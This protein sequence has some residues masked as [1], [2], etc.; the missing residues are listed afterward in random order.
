MAVPDPAIISP[1]SDAYVMS[2]NNLNLNDHM[3]GSKQLIYYSFFL[4]VLCF[5][6]NLNAQT[7]NYKIARG[8]VLDI[9]VMEHPEFSIKNII[10]FTKKV[11][12]DS[13]KFPIIL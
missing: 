8:D 5:S 4:L 12:L 7:K 1:L 3:L 13:N 2:L 6:S 9:M 10:I 11:N